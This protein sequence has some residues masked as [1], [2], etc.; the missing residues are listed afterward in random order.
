[1]F[2]G[3]PLRVTFRQSMPELIDWIHDTGLGHHRMIG[4]GHVG[5]EIGSWAA[6]A[7]PCLRK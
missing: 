3:N 6:M 2:P 5:Q 4:Y 1:M 7:G